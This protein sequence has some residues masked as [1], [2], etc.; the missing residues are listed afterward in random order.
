MEPKVYSVIK[1]KPQARINHFL[2]K[3]RTSMAGVL[4][5]FGSWEPNKSLGASCYKPDIKTQTGT[6]IF[7]A[8][9][10]TS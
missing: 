10:H 4:N 1:A 7:R 3:A 5:V 8:F 6:Y 2:E 9:A